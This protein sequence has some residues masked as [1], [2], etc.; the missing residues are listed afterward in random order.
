MEKTQKNDTKKNVA[1][2]IVSIFK[3]IK[4]ALLTGLIWFVGYSFN[5]HLFSF[6]FKDKKI[7][8]YDAKEI[9]ELDSPPS[10]YY[11]KPRSE[12]SNAGD[13][14]ISD[15]GILEVK[16]QIIRKLLWDSTFSSLIVILIFFSGLMML[17]Y[18][19]KVVNW[20]KKHAD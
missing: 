15:S 5:N 16:N 18:V 20:T 13:M 12:G 9:L 1:N 7:E 14:I 4:I 8:W 3:I 6:A 17:Y 10:E 11:F 19:K 2:E